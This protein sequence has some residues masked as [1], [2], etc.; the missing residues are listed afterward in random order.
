MAVLSEGAWLTISLSLPYCSSLLVELTPGV[1]L[2]VAALSDEPVRRMA[3]RL[4]QRE[5]EGGDAIV[6]RD[7]LPISVRR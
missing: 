1:L 2:R 6:C 7:P 4:P 5:D 3:P